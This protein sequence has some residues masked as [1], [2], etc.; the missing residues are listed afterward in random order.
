MKITITLSDA[1]VKGIRRYI[2]A[3]DESYDHPHM[4]GKD[5]ITDHIST[6]VHGNL[7]NPS[8]SVCDF[9]T[10]EEEKEGVKALN[11]KFDND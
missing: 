7:S 11:K 9:I 4:V 6:I 2:A 5:A 3:G 1:Q 10:E 8:E